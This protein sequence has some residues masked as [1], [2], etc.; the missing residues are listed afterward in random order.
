M[1]SQQFTDRATNAM[2][3]TPSYSQ[4]ASTSTNLAMS[5]M[6]QVINTTPVA[7]ASIPLNGPINPQDC[8]VHT[9]EGMAREIIDGVSSG[10]VGKQRDMEIYC[11]KLVDEL[12]KTLSKK[13]EE[14]IKA[15]FAKAMAVMGVR[16]TSATS[17][18]LTSATHTTPSN[19]DEVTAGASA[20]LEVLSKKVQTKLE[21]DELETSLNDP[22]VVTSYVSE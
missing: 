22:A 21:L 3:E 5:M 14:T 12:G 17:L 18:L 15:E 2:H 7:I 8:E 13:V 9:F 20:S 4:A 10:F 6:G 11:K 19:D 1:D 16:A